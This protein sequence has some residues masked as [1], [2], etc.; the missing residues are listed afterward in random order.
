MK[1]NSSYANFNNFDFSFK[2]S[3][4]DEIK[5]S[6][7]DNKSVEYESSRSSNAQSRSLTLTHEYGYSFSYV[8]NGLDENDKKELA[9]ALESIAPSIDE[10]MKNVKAGET[11][12][13]TKLTNLANSL[14]KELPTIKDINHKNFVSEGTLRLFDELLK[15]NKAD[16]NLL[17]T[18]KK[19]FDNLI[20]QLDSFKLYV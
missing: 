12:A 7:Y 17:E 20:E 1:I 3:S 6:M 16:L 14:K 4:G 5:F 2:T 13:F 11:P 19:L 18:S 10:F 15:Q 8:G 9:K